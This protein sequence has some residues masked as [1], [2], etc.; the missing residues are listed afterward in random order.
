[1]AL[2]SL[3]NDELLVDPER[4]DTVLALMGSPCANEEQPTQIVLIKLS[5]SQKHKKKAMNERKGT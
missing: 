3:L 5:E 1:M 2:L 4:A